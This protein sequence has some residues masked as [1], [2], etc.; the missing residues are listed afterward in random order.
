MW[1]NV[2]RGA[3]GVAVSLLTTLAFAGGASAATYYPSTFEDDYPTTPAH[4]EPGQQQPDP[5][6]EC[7]LREAIEAADGT[8]ADD[9]VAL[10]TG[11]YRLDW[12]RGALVVSDAT[13]AGALTV[14]G[15]GARETIIK[16]GL[17]GE[18]PPRRG[19]TFQAGARGELIDLAI[20]LGQGDAENQASPD[21]FD[22]GAI[23]VQD[24]DD[25]SEGAEGG[26]D[27]DVLLERVRLF[28]NSARSG[29]AIKN[30]GKLTISESLIDGNTAAWSGGAIE[31]DDELAILNST[32]T[33]NTA[34]GLGRGTDFSE[35]FPDDEDG[36]GGGID[37]DGNHSEEEPTGEFEQLDEWPGGPVVLVANSTIAHN[38]AKTLGGGVS[39]QVTPPSFDNTANPLALFVNSVVSENT[40][41]SGDNCSGN[42]G[43]SVPDSSLGHNIERGT[44]CEFT[45]EGDKTADPKLDELADNGGD[46]DTHAL[47]AGSPAIDAADNEL[48]TEIDQRDVERPQGPHC[49]MGAY[50]APGKA[51]PPTKPPSTPK[52]PGP[53]PKDPGP[54]PNPNPQPN[55]P[56]GEDPRCTD[57]VPP[58]THLK[59]GGLRINSKGV[60]LKG[61]SRD[62]QPCAS[63]V[64][65]VEVSLAKV[66]GTDLNCRFLRRSNRFLLSPFMN[67]RQSIR[68]VAKGTTRWKFT[69]KMDL[70]PGKYRATARGWDNADNKETPKK[71]RNIIYFTVK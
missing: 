22:G 21:F 15:M 68:F 23:A 44:S 11:T 42:D 10:E 5:E 12:D 30:R 32:I 14:E 47:L 29:G 26:N 9:D 24:N 54:Q 4:C 17:P 69:Y 51:T 64:Q 46:T 43:Q 61:K 16:P 20:T 57:S 33:R 13:G 67:C 7:S 49:D 56:R 59:R 52:D 37:N 55:V 65:R 3:A 70:K 53:Q 35:E 2:R 25:G 18:T 62:P 66:S 28:E 34:L 60:H 58:I 19:F 8:A 41:E 71:R 40:A 27:A 31:N 36:N 6:L 39:T 48:C 1:T 63:G 50:E 38:E 45:E